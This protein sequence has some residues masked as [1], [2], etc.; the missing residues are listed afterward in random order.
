[1]KKIKDFNKIEFIQNIEKKFKINITYFELNFK[2]SEI[3]LKFVEDSKVKNDEIMDYCINLIK[4]NIDLNSILD[5]YEK[6]VY[7]FDFNKSIKES[8]G[9]FRKIHN[10]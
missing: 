6:I 7:E 5:N 9:N 3:Q 8:Y 1:M 10:Q 4:K 2:N